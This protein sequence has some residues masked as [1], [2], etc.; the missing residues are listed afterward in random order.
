MSSS[1]WNGKAHTFDG[2]AGSPRALVRGKGGSPS[3]LLI[4]ML[5]VSVPA[6]VPPISVPEK[7]SSSTS[8]S[9][10]VQPEPLLLPASDDGR[11]S[12][13]PGTTPQNPKKN[14]KKKPRG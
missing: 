13:W 10:S 2:P 1:S 12:A 8:R 11:G 7:G 3:G 4:E 9:K 5:V 14:K 6:D